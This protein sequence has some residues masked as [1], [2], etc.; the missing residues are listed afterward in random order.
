MSELIKRFLFL[1]HFYVLTFIN[2]L[3]LTFYTVC[4]ATPNCNE[5]GFLNSLSTPSHSWIRNTTIVSFI[6]YCYPFRAPQIYRLHLRKHSMLL[7]AAIVCQ[8]TAFNS[9]ALRQPRAHCPLHLIQ[10][11]ARSETM[12]SQLYLQKSVTSLNLQCIRVSS[13]LP[14]I[15]FISSSSSS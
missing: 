8:R 10:T 2:F 1:S 12:A 15:S 7:S 3:F 13:R 6:V 11:G 5:P 14:P 9:I 4:L